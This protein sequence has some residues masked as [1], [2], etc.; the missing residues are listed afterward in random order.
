MQLQL[1][2]TGFVIFNAISFQLVWWSGVLYGNDAIALSLLL[3]LVHFLLS[4][5]KKM[6]FQIMLF[7]GGSGI[8][9]D[10][11]LMWSGFFE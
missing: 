8:L 6:D 7:F 4:L 9:V 2:K 11:I 3:L 1:S 10:C 5:Q